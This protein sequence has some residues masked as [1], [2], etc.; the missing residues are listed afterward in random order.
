MAIDC[1]WTTREHISLYLLHRLICV[2]FLS[3]CINATLHILCFVLSCLC[4]LPLSL[5]GAETRWPGLC[6]G[7][8]WSHR[9]HTITT[10]KTNTDW[11]LYILTADRFIIFMYA[12]IFFFTNTTYKWMC[13][14]AHKCRMQ[15]S[16]IAKLEQSRHL[17]CTDGQY[18]PAN[19]VLFLIPFG[20]GYWHQTLSHCWVCTNFTTMFKDTAWYK[21]EHAN[22]SLHLKSEL[23]FTHCRS[24]LALCFCFTDGLLIQ[25]HHCAAPQKAYY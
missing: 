21:Q 10:T 7:L 14:H 17:R 1:E 13:T 19:C 2:S 6:W 25:S 4:L 16:F 24:D 23:T 8:H 15:W 5:L 18:T 22:N 3:M 12:S 9:L 20:I 11:G